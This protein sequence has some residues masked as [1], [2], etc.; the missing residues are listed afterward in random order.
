[1]SYH[2]HDCPDGA[3]IV[4][5]LG[6]RRRGRQLRPLSFTT[7][8]VTRLEPVLDAARAAGAALA[9]LEIAPH[10]TSGG[11]Q[12]TADHRH[13]IQRRSARKWRRR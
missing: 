13:T 4:A 12:S 11:G 2:D 7:A 8:P 1:M 6:L 9:I 3:T 5:A 10:T